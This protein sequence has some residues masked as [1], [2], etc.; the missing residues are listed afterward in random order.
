[1]KHHE[2][3]RSAEMASIMRE[4]S[5]NIIEQKDLQGHVTHKE[6]QFGFN[7]NTASDT[8]QNRDVL[9]LIIQNDKSSKDVK[10][11]EQKLDS[12]PATGGGAFNNEELNGALENRDGTVQQDKEGIQ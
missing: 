9:Q 6:Y 1:M 4:Q 2:K 3:P 12:F 10:A 7:I 11:A 8:L 5:V